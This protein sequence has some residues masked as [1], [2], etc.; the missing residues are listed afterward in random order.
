MAGK[1]A[2]EALL[3]GA[4]AGRKR[5]WAALGVVLA[6]LVALL[7]AVL[8]RQEISERPREAPGKDS[9]RPCWSFF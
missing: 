5:S 7:A 1:T 9:G 3:G 2:P 4:W 8:T 6:A